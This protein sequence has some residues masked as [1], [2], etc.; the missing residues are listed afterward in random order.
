MKTTNTDIIGILKLV[1]ASSL[2]ALGGLVFPFL[3][4]FFPVLFLT[5]SFKQGIVRVML[6]FLGVCLIMGYILSPSAGIILLALFGPLIMTL[7]YCIR[8]RQ[9]VEVT[10]AAGILILLVSMV[11][12][13]YISG[14]L[15]AIQDGSLF[16]AVLSSQKLVLENAGMEADQVSSIIATTRTSL[17]LVHSLMPAILLLSSI[18]IVYI[19][20]SMTGRRLLSQ[21]KLIKQPSSFIF[22]RLPRQ[23]VLPA[24]LTLLVLILGQSLADV[25]LEI[26]IRNLSLTVTALLAFQGLAVAGFYIMKWVSSSIA[27][28]IIM[29]LIFFIPGAQGVLSIVGLLDQGINLRRI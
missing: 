10:M 9:G 29:V 7:D 13:L 6:T 24:L 2:I 25:D 18:L 1:L 8:S 20:Y 21:G 11:F 26:V 3:F 19:S 12:V 28:V 27:R 16:E 14:T 4:L 17:R 23:L 5:E 15:E 22:F